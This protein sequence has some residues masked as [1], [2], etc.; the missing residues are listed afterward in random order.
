MQNLL[1]CWFQ[2]LINKNDQFQVPAIR[3]TL[4]QKM[5]ISTYLNNELN[6]FASRYRQSLYHEVRCRGH[7]LLRL[8]NFLHAN[9]SSYLRKKPHIWFLVAIL[10]FTTLLSILQSFKVRITRRSSRKYFINCIPHLIHICIQQKTSK[11]KCLQIQHERLRKTQ[12]S[13]LFD[14]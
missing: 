4:W 5:K 7:N 14:A 3:W 8:S 1:I 2:A 6:H 13:R 11:Q 10:H 12:L 9:Y